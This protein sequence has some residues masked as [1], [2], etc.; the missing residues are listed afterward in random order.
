MGEIKKGG[1]KY[2]DFVVFK[3]VPPPTPSK[4]IIYLDIAI[5]IVGILIITLA[6]ITFFGPDINSNTSGYNFIPSKQID[7]D[8]TP[9][10]SQNPNFPDKP[11]SEPIIPT[12]NKNKNIFEAYLNPPLKL[13]DWQAD[14][15]L[16]P[17][18]RPGILL[19]IQNEGENTYTINSV[20]VEGCGTLDLSSNPRILE[21]PNSPN[22]ANIAE[23]FLI[24]CT[25]EPGS[26]MVFNEIFKHDLMVS[27]KDSNNEENIVEGLFWSKVAK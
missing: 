11:I 16:A 23:T 26:N 5:A 21:S 15:T 27:Y 25:L 1:L 6:I 12:V 3:S 10:E 8:D 17:D 2:E 14:R 9:V 24:Y 22:Y 19:A 18:N 7:K 20:S 4:T 13:T